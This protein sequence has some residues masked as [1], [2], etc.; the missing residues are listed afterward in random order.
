MLPFNL[1]EEILSLKRD[2]VR[3]AISLM[4]R[5]DNSGNLY[6]YRFV[7]SLINIKNQYTYEQVNNE[8]MKEDQFIRLHRLCEQLRQKRIEQGA[9]ILSLP[10]ISFEISDD[11]SISIKMLS[12]DTP[13]RMI[14]AE[15]MILYNWLASRFC[16][17]NNIPFLYRAQ[18][19]PSEL[20]SI[21]DTGYVDY[22]FRQRR[23]LFPLVIDTK[24][25]P[26]TGLGLDVYSNLSSPI[27][28]YLDLVCQRQIKSYLLNNPPVYNLEEL[29]KIRISVST[30]L[31]DLNIVRRNRTRYWILKYL[32]MNIGKIYPATILDRMKGKYRVI[33]SDYLFTA[34]MKRESTH[35]FLEGQSVLVKVKRSDPWNDLLIL[36]Y[37]GKPDPL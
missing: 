6:D 35:D 16:R 1:S 24:P 14:I 34:E 20:L 3:Q 37:A 31:K 18:K 25:L 21:T 36:E 23:K 17:D 22:V 2:S 7:P 19:S 12:Q 11:S 28:R 26:H 27:R 15:F 33:F 29:D 5:F 30:S 32:S 4:A 10:E 8:Y 9:L 13:S